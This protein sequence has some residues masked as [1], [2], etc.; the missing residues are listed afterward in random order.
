VVETTDAIKSP[1]KVVIVHRMT[2]IG[3]QKKKGLYGYCTGECGCCAR[4][5]GSYLP[6]RSIPEPLSYEDSD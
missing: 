2:I 6:D 3:L 4:F 5:K 1:L